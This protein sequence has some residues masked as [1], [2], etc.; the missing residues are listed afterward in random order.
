MSPLKIAETPQSF[1]EIQIQTLKIIEG[2]GKLEINKKLKLFLREAVMSHI[3]ECSWFSVVCAP[4]IT[5]IASLLIY[6]YLKSTII[7]N[8]LKFLMA[9][10]HDPYLTP[11]NKTF[12]LPPALWFENQSNIDIFYEI[13]NETKILSIIDSVSNIPLQKKIKGFIK[14]HQKMFLEFPLIEISATAKDFELEFNIHINYGKKE[15][16]LCYSLKHQTKNLISLKQT[17]T[18]L[19]HTIR[20]INI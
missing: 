5:T 14:P 20:K 19:R 8:K 3:L 7:K 10:P 1:N 9:K 6:D 4:I 2:Y 12:C 18:G 16:K 17:S 11:D 15:N 13:Q